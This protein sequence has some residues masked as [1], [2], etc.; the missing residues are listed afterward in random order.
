MDGKKPITETNDIKE[1]V[2]TIKAIERMGYALFGDPQNPT[3][4]PPMQFKILDA[5]PILRCMK[6]MREI[7]DDLASRLP[8]EVIAAEQAKV[9]PILRANTVPQGQA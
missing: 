6:I 4:F 7:H 5:E 2:D 3:I 8:P 1:A 9:A